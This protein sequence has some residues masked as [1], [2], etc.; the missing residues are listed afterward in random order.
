MGALLQLS[1]LQPQPSLP[2]VS[3]SLLLLLL[4]MLLLEPPPLSRYLMGTSVRQNCGRLGHCATATLVL[5]LLPLLLLMLYTMQAFAQ[6]SDRC[7][8]LW[9][10]QH[11]EEKE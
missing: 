6:S 3:P 5:L 1:R 8:Q 11:R 7:R 10:E 4:L 9:Q 2:S